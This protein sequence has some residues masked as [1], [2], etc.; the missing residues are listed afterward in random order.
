[1]PRKPT[2]RKRPIKIVG[3]SR[4]PSE[5]E[6]DEALRAAGITGIK[7]TPIQLHGFILKLVLKDRINNKEIKLITET[8]RDLIKHYWG[9]N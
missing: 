3:L 1:M 4:E 6:L 2:Q 9:Q 5:C 7:F 8:Y